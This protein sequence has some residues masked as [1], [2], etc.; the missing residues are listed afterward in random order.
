MGINLKIQVATEEHLP[1]VDTILQTIED[2][3]K[4]RGTGIAKRSPDYVALKM[5]E[6]KAIIA[7]N[8]NEFAGFCYIES[9]GHNK[10]VANSGLIVVEKFRG[11]GLAKDIKKMAFD[12]SRK[13][14]PDAKIFGLTTGLAVMKINSELGYRPVTF[15]ELTN[16]EA[17]WKGCQSCVNYDILMRT[18]RKHCLCTGMLYDPAWELNKKKSDAPDEKEMSV[19]GRWLK[20]KQSVL[21]KIKKG[22]GVKAAFFSLIGL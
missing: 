2:A 21:L 3:A 14:F 20:F 22:N 17:F 12:L 18:S 1:Y 7:L 6:G 5:T 15:S 10:F 11:H 9:W 13:K 8:N 4:V 16:D 19:Y